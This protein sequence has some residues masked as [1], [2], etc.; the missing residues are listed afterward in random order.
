MKILITGGTGFIGTKLCEYLQGRGHHLTVLSRRPEKVPEICGEK[1]KAITSIDDLPP[2]DHYEAIINLAGE[3]IADAR[4]SRTRKQIL[5]D[6]RIKTTE[7]LLN[8]I[9]RSKIKPDVMVSGSA[10]GFYGNQ[11]DVVLDENSDAVDDFSHQ[12]CEAWEQTAAGATELGVR[13]CIIRT[14]LVIDEGGGFLKRML[15]A[16]KIGLG[17][18]LGDGKQ[19]MSWVHRDDLI[20]IIALLLINPKLQGAFN[21]TAPNPVTNEQFTVC[22]AKLLKRPAPLPVPA[23]VLKILLGEMAE[24]LLGGQQVLPKRLQENNFFFQYELLEDALKNALKHT[25]T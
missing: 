10:V 1:V 6:S 5:L 11:G 13:V 8:F 7:K 12:L 24:L 3:G 20:R 23:K 18:R 15:P 9:E 21:A 14:G 25:E 2:D 17:G 22:L 4:W 19:W 16:F